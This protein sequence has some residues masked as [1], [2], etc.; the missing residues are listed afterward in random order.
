MKQSGAA[1]L[2]LLENR[3]GDTRIS[4]GLQTPAI[5]DFWQEDARG[6]EEMPALAYLG[7][8]RRSWS[9][10]PLLDA[11]LALIEAFAQQEVAFDLLK[12]CVDHVEPEIAWSAKRL[13]H[14]RT[15]RP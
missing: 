5:R 13:L 9:T 10:D 12:A 15:Q 8:A 2:E 3:S 4:R 1:L 6:D 14:A 7:A 11:Q